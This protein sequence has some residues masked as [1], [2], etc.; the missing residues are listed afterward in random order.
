MTDDCSRSVPRIQTHEPGL[1][2]HSRPNLTTKPLG[3]P[4]DLS[5]FELVVRI[6]VRNWHNHGK[7]AI[8]QIWE[9]RVPVLWN[10]SRLQ[11]SE[12]LIIKIQPFR[13]V[14]GAWVRRSCK[15]FES[16]LLEECQWTYTLS[17]RCR[18]FLDTT[19]WAWCLGHSQLRCA[20]ALLEMAR[21]RLTWLRREAHA[22][23]TN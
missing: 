18:G 11:S 7:E 22:I 4:Q 9:D 8:S 1:P 20:L 17:K 15:Y 19:M 3:W 5:I 14:P 10:Q 6:S 16:E 21:L 13:V 23:W 2:K 12:I